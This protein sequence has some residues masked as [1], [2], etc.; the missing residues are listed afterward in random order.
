M[1]LF[2]KPAVGI[3]SRPRNVQILTPSTKARA[4]I[5][6]FDSGVGGLAIYRA[7]RELLPAEDLIYIADSGFGPYG[8]R[9]TGFV[10]SRVTAMAA[11]LVELGAKA[12]VVACNTATVVAVERI[13]SLYGLPIIG[14][15]PAI[16]PAVATTRSKKMVVLATQRTIESEAVERLCR[17]HGRETEILRVPCPGL[18]EQVE[19]GSLEDE[20]TLHLL[21][22]YT[23]KALASGA[24]TFVLGCTHFVFLETQIRAL[25]G[26]EVAILEPSRAVARQVVRRLAEH[27]RC[28]EK[29]RGATE[30]FFTTARSPADAGAVMSKL[31]G[32]RVAVRS[33][34]DIHAQSPA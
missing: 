21:R 32:R 14:I 22:G 29:A 20:R 10:E 16:K 15:E 19:Q 31:L 8:D 24:D 7:V 5:G 25:V 23:R 13:R 9:N 6:I 4:P 11:A 12:I 17:L 3:R 28:A 2:R 1:D 34:H 27:C 26:P 18:V 33:A 30:Q